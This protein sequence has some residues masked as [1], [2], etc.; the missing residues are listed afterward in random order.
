M[1]D[2][3]KKQIED[4]MRQIDEQKDDN[5][6]TGTKNTVH[7]YILDASTQGNKPGEQVKQAL[8]HNRL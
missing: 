5:D 1:E 8:L 3:L 7:V 2:N 4:I 6:S